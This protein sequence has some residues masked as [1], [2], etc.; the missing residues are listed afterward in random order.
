MDRDQELDD[1]LLSGEHAGL[2]I[3]FDP[4]PGVRV[5]AG[6]QFMQRVFSLQ[7]SFVHHLEDITARGLIIF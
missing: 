4:C 2:E 5:C 6:V 3:A 1:S 7:P